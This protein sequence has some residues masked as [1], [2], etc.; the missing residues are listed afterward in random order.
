M[1]LFKFDNQLNILPFDGEVFYFGEVLGDVGKIKQVL[2]QKV[3]WQPDQLLIYGKHITTKRK[4]A[5]YGDKAFNYSYSNS[6]RTAQS[7]IT[8][9]LVLKEIV[10]DLTQHSFNSCLLNLYHKGDEGM[11]WHSDD[12]PELGI[13][14]VI[15][16]LSIG[17]ERKFSFKH[18]KNKETRSLQLENG[19]LLIMKGETQRYW[20][21]S[22][23]KTSRVNEPRINLTFRTILNNN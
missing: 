22:L 12:E 15:A 14:P 1:K 11:A 10:E 16:S 3:D 20:K 23:P 9:L 5:W 19:S 21:H 7:W 13:N 4:T 18:K 6:T 17:A 8:E 2:L